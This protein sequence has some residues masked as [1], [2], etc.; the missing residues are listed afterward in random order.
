MLGEFENLEG[1]MRNIEKRVL[2]LANC[3]EPIQYMSMQVH[4]YNSC[5]LYSIQKESFSANSIG[6][7]VTANDLRHSI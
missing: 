6:P 3:I 2:I 5:Q 1:S 7:I 4:K